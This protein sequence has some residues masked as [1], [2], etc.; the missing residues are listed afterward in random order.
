MSSRPLQ[1]SDSH[2]LMGIPCGPSVQALGL[3]LSPTLIW[4]VPAFFARPH[5]PFSW[6]SMN[7]STLLSKSCWILSVPACPCLSAVLLSSSPCPS[8][9]GL[10]GVGVCS[11][12]LP[13][14]WPPSP[15]SVNPAPGAQVSQISGDPPSLLV[16]LSAFTL[17]DGNIHT[18]GPWLF[19][20]PHGQPL[21]VDDS[22]GTPS[23]H[24][25]PSIFPIFSLEPESPR[26]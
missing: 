8:D 25:L 12:V 1:H 23:N 24:P 15:S 18:E 3:P 10:T 9:T 6:S 22:Y 14:H 20:A 13:L 16:T 2:C 11:S 5:A 7:S 21:T 26:P 19:S 17:G 4:P